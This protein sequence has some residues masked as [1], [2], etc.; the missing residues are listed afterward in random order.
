[1]YLKV[2]SWNHFHF[3][4]LTTKI[5]ILFYLPAYISAV[6]IVNNTYTRGFNPIHIQYKFV[7]IISGRP[8]IQATFFSFIYQ[9]RM[10][11]SPAS[12]P[13]KAQP[14]YT[15]QPFSS[16]L[17]VLHLASFSSHSLL[18]IISIQMEFFFFVTTFYFPSF[19]I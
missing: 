14:L 5:F 11:D 18:F 1:M 8:V 7:K 10:D 2:L 6:V 15:H 3:Y 16:F 19:S 9:A 13:F 4:P 17:S 12:T